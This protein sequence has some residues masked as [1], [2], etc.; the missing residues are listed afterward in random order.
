MSR[1]IL[2]VLP[3][4]FADNDRREFCPECAELAG[5]LS[6]YPFIRDAL[7]IRHIGIKHPREPITEMLG[8][9]NYNAPTL[10]LAEGTDL[11]TQIA[12]K[13]ANGWR[14]LDSISMISAFFSGRYG[15]PNR[16]GDT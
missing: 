12:G 15:L 10:V 6:Y 3:P 8:H 14:Y 16:R 11:P 1:D 7:D 2:F 9:G 5:L 13:T 4:G